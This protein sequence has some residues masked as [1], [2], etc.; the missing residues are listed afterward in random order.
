MKMHW[1]VAKND[2]HNKP[3]YHLRKGGQRNNNWHHQ[4]NLT[5]TIAPMTYVISSIAFID[6]KYSKIFQRKYNDDSVCNIDAGA[7]DH[8]TSNKSNFF[9]YKRGLI[10]FTRSFLETTARRML[11]ARRNYIV[12]LALIMKIV[13]FQ[14]ML[15]EWTTFCLLQN[16]TKLQTCVL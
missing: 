10:V 5:A 14:I 2:S 9:S 16:W 12:I 4:R 13:S 7:S 6:R 8:M 1:T 15:L 11:K 3:N